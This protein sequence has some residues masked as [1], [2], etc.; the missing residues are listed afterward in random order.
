MPDHPG[1]G[2]RSE[3]PFLNAAGL[4]IMMAMKHTPAVTCPPLAAPAVRRLAD[5]VEVPGE[6]CAPG[7]PG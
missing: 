5:A 3:F 1:P 6:R 7:W 4:R 2:A